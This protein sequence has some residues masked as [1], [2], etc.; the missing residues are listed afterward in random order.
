MNELRP[1]NVWV[2]Y[3]G[4]SSEREVSLRTGKGIL[5]ALAEKGFSA[6]GFDVR[7]GELSELPWKEQKPDIV[8]IGLHGHFGEDGAI[9]GF[10]EAQGVF[11]VGSGVMS[12]AI[13]F[14]KGFSKH[15]LREAGIPV[16][17]SYDFE[18]EEHFLR[19]S[20]RQT[21][22]SDFYQKK[23]FIKPAQEGS[24]IGIERYDPTRIEGSRRQEVF[25]DLLKN[26]LEYC[27]DI[28]VEE[29]I[30]GPEVTVPVFDG[31]ALPA[32][33][34]RP[35]SHFFDYKSKYTVGETD[36]ICP[37]ELNENLLRE[38]GEISVRSFH[39]LKCAD[40]GRV[41]LMISPDGPVVLEMNTLPGMTE[42]SLVP[43]S[44]KVAGMDYGTFVEKLV[45]ASFTRQ[46]HGKCT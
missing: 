30:E 33:E 38:I 25:F 14:H 36:Y 11:Y 9:Q 37:A 24:T 32:V 12:S 28:L 1:K 7:P 45:C 27:S 34:V 46:S 20:R 2:L 39:A 19:E 13:S 6:Q 44:A 4:N 15:I 43:K 18:G 40:Y 35:K 16:P 10:L 8:F 31:R 22:P 29:W 3:G 42:T 26:S 5:N 17:K 21:L 41:D 23:W